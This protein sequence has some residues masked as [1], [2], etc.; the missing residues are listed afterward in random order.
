MEKKKPIR[1]CV[2]C[3]ASKEKAELYRI[4]R[5]PENEILL[6][7]TGRKNGRGAYICKDVKCIEKAK[8]LGS[9][10]KA[11]GIS[12]SDEIYESLMEGFAE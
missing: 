2:G 9:L 1:R 11:F 8:K 4:I 6:D 7:K 3:G 12:V 5:T 10:S